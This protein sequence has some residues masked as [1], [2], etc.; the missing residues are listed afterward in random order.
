MTAVHLVILG[1]QGSGKGTQAARLV[2]AYSPIHVSTGD[3]LRAA[4][5]DGTEL[6]RRAGALMDAGDLVGDDLING[7]VAERLAQPDVAEHGFL[8]DGYPRT[9][10]QAAAMEGF[11]AEAGTTLDGAVNLDVPVDEVTARMLARGRADDTEEAIRRRLDLYEAETAP[12]L[13][14]FADRGLLDVVDGIGDEDVVFGR[15]STVIDARLS[16]LDAS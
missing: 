12:L 16:L 11:L 6:G 8:L 3:M 14:W 15:L 13:V 10:D 1:R 2:E 5:A 9:P 7:I 4:V